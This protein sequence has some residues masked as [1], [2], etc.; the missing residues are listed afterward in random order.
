MKIAARTHPK[1][2]D[3]CDRLQCS[4]P[5]AIG[6]LEL[7]WAG[8][9]EHAPAGNI[10]KFTDGA[11]AKW[12]DWTGDPADFVAAMVESRWIDEDAKHRL[13]VH[14]W[15]EHCPNWLKT[16]MRRMRLNFVNPTDSTYERSNEHSIERSV[17]PTI[18]PA[19][20]CSIEPS[21]ENSVERST[22]HVTPRH[23]TPRP[24][25]SSEREQQAERNRWEMAMSAAAA[26][27]FEHPR[28]P[29]EDCRERGVG[30]GE[31]EAVLDYWREHSR[32]FAGPGALSSK[33]SGMFPGQPVESGWPKRSKPPPGNTD[34]GSE[35]TAV[36][37]MAD[38]ELNALAA[39]VFAGKAGLMANWKD[40]GRKSE[41]CIEHIARFRIRSRN[42][43][44]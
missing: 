26:A 34:I 33:L 2:Y 17:E 30:V 42:G 25:T 22:R 36:R 3:L 14:D 27:G 39:E 5:A 13:V 37:A 44:V 21:T 9:S 8:A 38:D 15:A 1:L 16:K 11:I 29:I 19:N 18:E 35:C 6:Y 20:E 41:T 12:C 28:K 43:G 7:M 24:A 10:G 23:A 31:V 32:E 4:R 40:S